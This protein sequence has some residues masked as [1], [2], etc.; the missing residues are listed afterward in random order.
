M[1]V[2][3]T[4]D[5]SSDKKIITSYAQKPTSPIVV[6]YLVFYNTFQTIGWGLILFF[7]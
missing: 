6:F 3:N 7:F 5:R 2:G 1:E 4:L